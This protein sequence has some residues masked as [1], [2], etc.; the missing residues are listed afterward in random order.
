MPSDMA[1]ALF[2]LTKSFK[3]CSCNYT[4]REKSGRLKTMEPIDY[5][6]QILEAMLPAVD[7]TTAAE[8]TTRQTE[9]SWQ[10]SS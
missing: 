7:P 9:I 3:S 2:W 5:I 4:G 1:S 8:K 10:R 6:G